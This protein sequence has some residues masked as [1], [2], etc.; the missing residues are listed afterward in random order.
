MWY[1]GNTYTNQRVNLHLGEFVPIWNKCSWL[2]GGKV[3]VYLVSIKTK[4]IG[5]NWY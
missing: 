4:H 3:T 1:Q 5:N 2:Q